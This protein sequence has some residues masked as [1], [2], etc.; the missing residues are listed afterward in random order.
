M[1]TLFEQQIDHLHETHFL[2]LY[3][4][5]QAEDRGVPYNITN[6]FDDLKFHRITR[7]KQNAVAVVDALRALCFLTAREEGNRRNLYITEHG[8]KAL[9]KLVLEQRFTLRHSAFLEGPTR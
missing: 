9:E 5:A 7:T 2:V 6:S 3:W 4:V 8:A 1:D